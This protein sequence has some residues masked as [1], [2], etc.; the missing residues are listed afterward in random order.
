MENG[1]NNMYELPTAIR[2][3]FAFL[4]F[5]IKYRSVKEKK[6]LILSHYSEWEPA[7]ILYVCV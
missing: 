6:S 4:I 2:N 1:K 5:Y 3:T 7:F